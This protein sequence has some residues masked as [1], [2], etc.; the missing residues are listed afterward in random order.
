M[1][2]NSIKNFLTLL[3]SDNF[4]LESHL[5]FRPTKS[6]FSVYFFKS[7]CL[8]FSKNKKTGMYNINVPI[9]YSSFF[10]ES[11]KLKNSIKIIIN[12]I[13]SLENL[14]ISIKELYKNMESNCNSGGMFGCCHLYQECSDNKQCIHHN[15][16]FSNRCYYKGNLTKGKIFYGKHRNI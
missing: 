1:D 4:N 7:L 3:L 6:G 16:V 13:V 5:D 8:K 11:N 10:P 9:E 14:K 15:V 12:D 2:D